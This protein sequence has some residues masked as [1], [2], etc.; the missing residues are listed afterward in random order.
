MK[1]LIE[2]INTENDLM[3]SSLTKDNDI[4]N[5]DTVNE[6]QSTEYELEQYIEEQ[7]NIDE[8]NYRI[9][10]SRNYRT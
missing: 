9:F 7:K 4:T 1:N 8:L 10:L 5:Y 3:N 2:Y 6:D